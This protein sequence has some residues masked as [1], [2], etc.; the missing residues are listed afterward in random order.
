MNDERDKQGLV[1]DSDEDWAKAFAALEKKAQPD[2][3]AVAAD[4]VAEEDR[5]GAAAADEGALLAAG[6]SGSDDAGMGDGDAGGPVPSAGEGGEGDDLPDVEATIAQYRET[7][8]TRALE[9]T[10][11]L[12]LEKTDENG[13]RIIR[14]TDGRL[15]ATISDPD[16][17]RVDE[18]GVATFYNPD[19]GKPFTGDNPR[20]QAKQWVEMYNEELRDT[21]NKFVENRR[22]E[23]EDEAAPALRLLEFIPTFESLDPVR[24]KM[25]DALI[26]DYE[27]TDSDGD[28]IG[29]SVDLNAALAQVN[30]QIESIKASAVKPEPTSPSVDMPVSGSSQGAGTNRPIQSLAEALEMQ[31]ERKLASFRNKD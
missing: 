12:F 11:R 1:P 30:R 7:I 3:D 25:L 17:Y 5:P 16:I 18:N 4:D 26:E 2:T 14:Q 15:G 24:Q 10:A 8:E 22:T 13:N 27:V 21:F 6:V 19:T 20:A 23:L 28:V 31:E 9:E 29:Y